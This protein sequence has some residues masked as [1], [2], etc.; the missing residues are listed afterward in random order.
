MKIR[1]LPA[2]LIAGFFST[3][4][5]ADVDTPLAET[6][7]PES[8]GST[9]ECTYHSTLTPDNEVKLVILHGDPGCG[10][11]QG[12]VR[13]RTEAAKRYVRAG[14]I[15]RNMLTDESMNCHVLSRP[16]HGTTGNVTY[17]QGALGFLETLKD[18]QSFILEDEG[19]KAVLKAKAATVVGELDW[20]TVPSERVENTKCNFHYIVEPQNWV[21]SGFVRRNAKS[22]LY[23]VPAGLGTLVVAGSENVRWFA[24]KVS[25][26]YG[27]YVSDTVTY[28]LA[29]LVFL[30]TQV[31]AY[32]MKGPGAAKKD[33]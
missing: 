25:D 4:L 11:E 29:G 1:V 17:Y 28:V 26:V 24:Y 2:W 33:N 20:A 23:S 10:L 8:P 14:N 18:T 21:H 22:L 15:D 32:R 16:E 19:E 9:F 6:D 7:R 30:G 27:S 31:V 12:D 13:T 5:L 3:S